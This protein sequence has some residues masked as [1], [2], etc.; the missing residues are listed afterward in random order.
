MNAF[1]HLWQSARALAVALWARKQ[2]RDRERLVLPACCVCEH[3]RTPGVPVQFLL[4]LYPRNTN[5][6]SSEVLEM[7]RYVCGAH[8]PV[9]GVGKI[10]RSLEASAYFDYLGYSA[11]I[12][13]YYVHRF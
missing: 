8:H 7:T 4:V 5:D 9:H 10:D 1:T 2:L 6:D 12:I 3:Y 13:V 11:R